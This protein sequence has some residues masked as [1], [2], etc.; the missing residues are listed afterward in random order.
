[1][2]CRSFHVWHPFDLVPSIQSGGW[3]SELSWS[4]EL[5]T[6]SCPALGS[7][8]VAVAVFL[9][10]CIV[11]V[12]ALLGY[13]FVKNQRK[14]FRGYHHSRRHP[15]PPTPASS[16]VS[17]TEDTEHLVYNHTTRPL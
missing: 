4:Q 8:E 9:A 14:G 12:V 1:M 17:T 5:F 11:V 13:C 6:L 10:A 3:A 7:A 16:T 2:C 15:Q